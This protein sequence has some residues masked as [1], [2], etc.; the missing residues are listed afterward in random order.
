MYLLSPAGWHISPPNRNERREEKNRLCSAHKCK[1]CINTEC[2]GS[3]GEANS[4]AIARMTQFPDFCSKQNVL[5]KRGSS[6][7]CSCK[8]LL[9]LSFF[10]FFFSPTS[11]MYLLVS[12]MHSVPPWHSEKP[13]SHEMKQSQVNHSKLGD[14]F[15]LCFSYSLSSW[16]NKLCLKTQVL[17][18]AFTAEENCNSVGYG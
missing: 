14:V 2:Q 11:F 17:W 9:P 5:V 16:S 1:V 3:S 15:W 6:K 13:W 12:S 18:G 8:D 4:P 10:P 7:D